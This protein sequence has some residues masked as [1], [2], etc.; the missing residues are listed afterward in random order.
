MPSQNYS[1]LSYGDKGN[2]FVLV[3][4]KTPKFYLKKEEKNLIW[5]GVTK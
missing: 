1:Q 3:K 4:K 2:F 5:V